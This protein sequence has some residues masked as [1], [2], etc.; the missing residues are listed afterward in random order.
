LTAARVL[1]TSF[2]GNPSARWTKLPDMARRALLLANAR[3]RLERYATLL[4][5]L[6]QA[7]RLSR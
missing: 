2:A 3:R 5:Q 1:Q 6:A 4:R 7:C